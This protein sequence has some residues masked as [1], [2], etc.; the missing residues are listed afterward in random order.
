MQNA[1]TYLMKGRRRILTENLRQKGITD[2]NV[3]NA[4]NTV[5]RHLF[6]LNGLEDHAYEDKA[7]SIDAG[8]TISQ[9][10]TVAFQTQLLK[11]QKTDKV[12]EIGTGS[13]YQ[14]AVLSQI[15]SQV[16][17]VE[18]IENLY[19]KAK[20]LLN[21][22]NYKNIHLYYADGYK[23]LENFAPFD[24]IIITA[25]IDKVPDVLLKQ[26]KIGGSLVAPIGNTNSA[27]TMTKIDRIDNEK[28]E[29]QTFGFFSFVPMLKGKI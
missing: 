13:G 25:S 28:F 27:Q 19:L 17:T 6:V 14:A 23:G 18:R 3:L 16:F 22:L 9:P 21:S 4:I 8:Q 2:E 29:Q 10:Y 24:K 5:P 11:P 7:L 15:V 12:L 26:L 20:K 1:D